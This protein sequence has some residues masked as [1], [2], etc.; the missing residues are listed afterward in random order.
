MGA[1]GRGGISLSLLLLPLLLLSFFFSPPI[2]AAAVDV[3]AQA[4]AWLPVGGEAV[5]TAVAAGAQS[6]IELQCLL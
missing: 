5:A 2:V 1:R 4:A 3:A 6:G